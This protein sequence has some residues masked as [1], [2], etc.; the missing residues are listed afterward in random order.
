MESTQ[1]LPGLLEAFAPERRDG[2]PAWLADRRDRARGHFEAV[3]FPS[4]KLEAWKNTNVSAI[5]STSYAPAPQGGGAA[6]AGHPALGFC[7]RR[8]VF[9]DGRLDESLSTGLGDRDGVWVGNLAQALEQHA[10]AVEGALARRVTAEGHP[11][12]ALNTA[13]FEQ[14]TVIRAHGAAAEPLHVLH[15]ASRTEQPAA[16][17]PRTLVLVEPQAEL[18]L[19]ESFFGAEDAAGLTCGVTEIDVA[20]NAGLEHMR[21]QFEAGAAHHVGATHA[22]VARSARYTCHA[23]DFG[24]RLARVDSTARLDG[25][26]SN[27]L[28]NCLYLVSG[29]QHVDNHT[30]LDHALPH[31]DSREVYKGILADSARAV[32]NGRIRVQQDAQKT[33]AKQ[34]NPNLLLT[35]GALVHTRPQLEIYA[36]DVKCT[37]G[38]TIGELDPEAMF[39]LRSRGIGDTEARNMLVRG[40]AGEL[41][42]QVPVEPVRAF[43]DRAFVQRLDAIQHG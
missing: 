23:F 26:G 37:H 32:F 24:S 35:E 2:E 41:L 22:T 12:A 16:A 15:L 1:Q 28:L 38:A 27:C 8:V 6:F 25:E 20:E 36:D 18:K 17:F 14:A 31:G 43:L 5:A 33:D 42:E 13:L 3:G 34:S 40:F 7:D 29:E 30:M 39:Y 10:D 9:V 11:F 21:L 19:V 4:S